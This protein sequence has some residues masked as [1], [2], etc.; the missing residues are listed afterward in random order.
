ME[1]KQEFT[2]VCF[3]SVKTEVLYVRGFVFSYKRL[4][5][6]RESKGSQHSWNII[7]FN[8]HTS[9]LTNSAMVLK[10]EHNVKN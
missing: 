2:A 7:S 8:K 5:S 10:T 6:R 3:G 9:D 1:F 4:N